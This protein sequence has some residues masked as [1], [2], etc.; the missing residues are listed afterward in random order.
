M[1]IKSKY[2][3]LK[4][5][6]RLAE[7][8]GTDA[9]RDNANRRISEIEAKLKDHFEELKKNF[10]PSLE[11]VYKQKTPNKKK[12]VINMRQ[13]KPLKVGIEPPFGWKKDAEVEIV[14]VFNVD[15][16]CFMLEWK[17][18]C[19]GGHIEKILPHDRVVR[20]SVKDGIR[21][22]IEDISKGRLNQLCD[23]CY[24]NHM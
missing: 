5:I 23:S 2:D 14:S 9:E 12:I 24:K 1:D 16:K 18:P 3:L 4:K 7:N 21:R 10:K 15:N 6:K 11:L 17:C 8:A 13:N 20:L 19:C 22:F